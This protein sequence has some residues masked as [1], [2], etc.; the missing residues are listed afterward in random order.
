MIR[1]SE[2]KDKQL[3]T[4]INGEFNDISSAHENKQQNITVQRLL[5]NY[6]KNTFIHRYKDS[7]V[8]LVF[9]CDDA[10]LKKLSNFSEQTSNSSAFLNVMCLLTYVLN[11]EEHI[12]LSGLSVIQV[13]C[14]RV[15]E[16][17]L[18]LI[19]T[20]IRSFG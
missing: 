12:Y 8:I 18:Y 7:E 15:R 19:L 16:G 13:N 4:Q 9:Q 20:L 1:I 2:T 6:K 5:Q 11:C 14:N 10:G 17:F 3:I